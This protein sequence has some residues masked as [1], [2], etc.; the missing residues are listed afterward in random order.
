MIKRSVVYEIF[1]DWASQIV[2]EMDF[3][4]SRTLM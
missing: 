4:T 1:V 2:S 3:T